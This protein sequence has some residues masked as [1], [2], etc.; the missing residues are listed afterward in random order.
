MKKLSKSKEPLYAFS[1]FGP[2]LLGVLLSAYLLDALIPAG[3][4]VNR[5]LWSFTGAPIVAVGLFSLIF[6]IVR[7][8]SGVFELKIATF[9]QNFNSKHGK[10]KFTML[11]SMF[12]MMLLYALLWLPPSREEGSLFNTFYILLIVIIYYIFSAVWH[13]SYFSTFQDILADERQRVRLSSWKAV[14]DTIAYSVAYALLPLFISMGLNISQ[15]VLYCIPLMLTMIIPQFVLKN[16]KNAPATQSLPE[17]TTIVKSLKSTL[18]Y[19]DFV[20]YLVVVGIM[21]FGLQMF[22]S[23]QNVIASG[24]LKLEGWQIAVMN[25]SVFAPVP[26]AILIF[27]KIQKTRGIRASF[28]IALICFAIAMSSYTIC[29]QFFSGAEWYI[30]VAIVG[31]GGLFGSYSIAVFFAALYIIPAQIAAND[32]KKTGVNA[33][34]M[35]LVV[36][37][38]LLQFTAAISVSLIYIN[39]KSISVDGNEFFGI[40]LVAPIVLVVTLVSLIFSSKMPKSYEE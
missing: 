11:I 33:T 12:P 32:M 39:L 26:L 2:N 1:T 36:Q 17:K 25:A 35:F 3:L 19:K 38:L 20:K 28:Q 29:G 13:L 10:F 34:P 8:F 37:T 16:D 30:R 9:L 31:V 6:T 22:L 40:S 21:W 14:F 24:M 15:I 7:I 4:D 5:N 23:A 18:A 27:N